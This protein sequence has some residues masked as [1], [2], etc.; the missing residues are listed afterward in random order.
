MFFSIEQDAYFC[1]V[2][3]HGRPDFGKPLT[4]FDDVRFLVPIFAFLHSEA[5]NYLS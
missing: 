4:L 1:F 5:A 2:S 3:F